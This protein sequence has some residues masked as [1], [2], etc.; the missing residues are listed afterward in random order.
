MRLTCVNKLPCG[1]DLSGCRGGGALLHQHKEHLSQRDVTPK[2]MLLDTANT[3][4]LCDFGS[5]KIGVGRPCRLVSTL[6]VR[7]PEKITKSGHHASM[8]WWVAASRM[9]L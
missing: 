2:N 7:G 1:A 3:C 8:D 4:K 6:G 9:S 5:A